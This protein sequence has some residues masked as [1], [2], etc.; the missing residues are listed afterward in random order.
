[1]KL[2]KACDRFFRKKNLRKFTKR[3]TKLHKLRAGFSLNLF[4]TLDP[5]DTFTVYLGKT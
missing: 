2:E 1:M 4:I 5:E 3:F